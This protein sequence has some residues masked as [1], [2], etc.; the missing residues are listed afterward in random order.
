MVFQEDDVATT[1]RMNAFEAL[2]AALTLNL[3]LL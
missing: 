1:T 3:T 2:M